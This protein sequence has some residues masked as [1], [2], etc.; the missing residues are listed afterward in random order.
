MVPP[1]LGAFA[2]RQRISTYGSAVLRCSGLAGHPVLDVGTAAD[3]SQRFQA[4]LTGCATSAASRDMRRRPR[5]L[6][7]SMTPRDQITVNLTFAN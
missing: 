7:S 5:A 6:F 4:T 2:P 3:A 1:K